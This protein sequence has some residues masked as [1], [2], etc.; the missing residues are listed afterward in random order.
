[1]DTITS[2]WKFDDKQDIYIVSKYLPTRYLLII[3]GKHSNFLK[4]P[5]KH[6][7]HQGG[8][9]V[10]CNDT[11]RTEHHPCGMPATNAQPLITMRNI[12]QAQT[13][14]RYKMK[15][16]SSSKVL[17]QERQRNADSELLWI[18]GRLYRWELNATCDLVLDHGPESSYFPFPIMGIRR[19]GEMW[20]RFMDYMLVLYQS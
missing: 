15:G 18:K 16:L 20:I 5:G 8:Q 4:P 10:H 1:M 9:E 2:R 7:L 3:K 19:I 13:K 14:G 6:L 17:S 12:K 11:L